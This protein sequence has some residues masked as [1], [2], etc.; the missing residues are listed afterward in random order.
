MLCPLCDQEISDESKYCCKC[1]RQIPRCPSC[2]EVLRS[3]APYCPKDGTVIPEDILLMVPEASQTKPAEPGLTTFP[4][5]I[6]DGPDDFSIDEPKSIETTPDNSLRCCARCSTI[7]SEGHLCPACGFGLS[8]P[9]SSTQVTPP[10]P[11]KPRPSRVTTILII[12]L[13]LALI[14]VGVMGYYIWS[15]LP[16][17][18]QPDTDVPGIST[19]YED[20]DTHQPG[21]TD[22]QTPTEETEPETQPTEPVITYESRYIVIPADVTW[23]EAKQACESMGGTLATITS[24]EEFEK[25]CEQADA[26]GLTYLWL[27]A[28]LQNASD[29]WSEATWITGE[30]WSYTNWY[31]GEPSKQDADGTLE[32]YL[33]MWHVKYDG[34]VIGWTFNDQRNDIISV[35]PKAAGK[36]GYVCEYKVEVVQ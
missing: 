11:V 19:G 8:F 10:D 25:V 15:T 5:D 2:G 29:E 9:P 28:C 27:G 21:N 31:P 3:R 20:D 34:N 4:I 12:A 14:T 1:G 32:S 7:Y 35:L 17:G 33:C 23:L 30:P 16:Q 6:F 22:V 13:V 26:S 36:I 24:R 18:T